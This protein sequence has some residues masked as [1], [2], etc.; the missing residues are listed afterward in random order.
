MEDI[1]SEDEKRVELYLQKFGIDYSQ[2]KAIHH[3]IPIEQE[4]LDLE[5]YLKKFDIRLSDFEFNLRTVTIQKTDKHYKRL[6][7]HIID[8]MFVERL[9]KERID[10][11]STIHINGIFPTPSMFC[12]LVL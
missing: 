11:E 5:S 1:W 8:I 9:L 4:K 2:V 6:L 7:V 12:E 10:G 3:K